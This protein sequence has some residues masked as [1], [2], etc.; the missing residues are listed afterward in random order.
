MT[1]YKDL[2]KEV[3]EKYD[4][5]TY[6]F[7]EYGLGFIDAPSIYNDASNYFHQ[8]LR[9]NCGSYGFEA[10]MEVWNNG[11]AKEIWR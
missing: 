11:T 5:Y 2:Q 3:L 9:L 6:N 1:A 10:P 7:Q 8:H 4:D